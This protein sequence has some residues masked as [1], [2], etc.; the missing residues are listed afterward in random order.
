M[1]GTVAL[2]SGSVVMDTNLLDTSRLKA[3]DEMGRVMLCDTI[4]K[5]AIMETPELIKASLLEWLF[6]GQDIHDLNERDSADAILLNA[7]VWL[8]GQSGNSIDSIRRH[9]SIP[10]EYLKPFHDAA[11]RNDDIPT[12]EQLEESIGWDG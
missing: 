1:E 11:S 12:P 3:L 10:T 9:V 4:A 6:N 5:E 7:V 8:M 2:L